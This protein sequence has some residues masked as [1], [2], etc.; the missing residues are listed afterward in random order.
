MCA[1]IKKETHKYITISAINALLTQY[2]HLNWREDRKEK[3]KR[4]GEVLALSYFLLHP[5]P[6]SPS[7]LSAPVK[8]SWLEKRPQGS[9]GV[10]SLWVRLTG[11]EQDRFQKENRDNW[12][13]QASD[14]VWIYSTITREAR[15]STFPVVTWCGDEG[16]NADGLVVSKRFSQ[17]LLKRLEL[18]SWL[19][20]DVYQGTK[21]NKCLCFW[22]NPDGETS[23]GGAAHGNH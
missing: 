3:T 16:M 21:V 20:C 2:S 22:Q 6:S 1:V 14:W 11:K 19:D 10:G 8:T 17:L 13:T 23:T 4:K 12:K 7:F 5:F 15:K 9:R 18:W